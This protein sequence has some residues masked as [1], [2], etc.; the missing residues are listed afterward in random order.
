MDGQ[1]RRGPRA[2]KPVAEKVPL[3]HRR[4]A[5]V[6]LG[7]P[8]R[9]PRRRP[10]PG[11][12]RSGRWAARRR[13]RREAEPVGSLEEVPGRPLDLPRPSHVPV[14]GP[15][16]ASARRRSPAAGTGQARTTP[17]GSECKARGVRV[18]DPG[19]RARRR[20]DVD[21]PRASP[22]T[23]PAPA[24]PRAPP[25]RLRSPLRRR[26][27]SRGPQGGGVIR[28]PRARPHLLL[29]LSPTRRPGRSLTRSAESGV[30]ASWRRAARRRRGRLGRGGR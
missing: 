11:P 13:R 3:D 15:G 1:A 4:L 30:W 28:G 12:G 16:R 2:W 20:G 17:G 29:S 9:R 6:G 7:V 18:S 24:P 10:G 22:A 14:Q 21:G 19:R 25:P 26:R 5:L 8:A 23:P 27:R